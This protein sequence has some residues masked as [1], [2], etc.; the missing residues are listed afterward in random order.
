M[1]EGL[2]FR[3]GVKRRPFWRDDSGGGDLNGDLEER[4]PRQGGQEV[5]RRWN[6]G[7]HLRKR[8]CC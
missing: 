7:A 8:K 4:H 2:V 3:K 5:G 1:S 6:R